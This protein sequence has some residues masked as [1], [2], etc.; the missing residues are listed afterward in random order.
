MDQVA[1]DDQAKAAAQDAVASYAAL[2]G[3]LRRQ[4]IA[5]GFEPAQA[6]ELVQTYMEGRQ[7]AAAIE[8]D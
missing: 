1:A 5:Q 3:G 7:L 4:L 6:F 8:D 2:L